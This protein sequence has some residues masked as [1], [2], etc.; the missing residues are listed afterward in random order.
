MEVTEQTPQIVVDNT[1]KP[2]KR[3]PKEP[4]LLDNIE[5]YNIWDTL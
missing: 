2:K 4:S 5:P 3:I 1:T